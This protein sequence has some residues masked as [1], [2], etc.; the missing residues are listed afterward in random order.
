MDTKKVIL[1][2]GINSKSEIDSIF[3]TEAQKRGMKLTDIEEKQGNSSLSLNDLE[4]ISSIPVKDVSSRKNGS[5]VFDGIEGLVK[6]A[7][8]S[9]SF[10][11]VKVNGDLNSSTVT[12]RSKN[13]QKPPESD[14]ELDISDSEDSLSSSRISQDS[15]PKSNRTS[16]NDNFQAKLKDEQS[17]R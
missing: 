10:N 7:K 1:A 17:Q 5:T 11:N 16:K 4:T 15:S 2:N 6:V 14:Y 12:K 13:K 8:G 3:S 9:N